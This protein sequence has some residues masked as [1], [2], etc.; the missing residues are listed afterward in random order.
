MM[1]PGAILM[2]DPE[3]MRRR[4][5]DLTKQAEKIR[6]ETAPLRWKRDEALASIA[7]RV[8][9]LETQ[10]KALE[11]PLFDIEQERAIISRALN[12]KTGSVA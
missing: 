4:F 8:T 7:Q 9:A 6:A 10:I 11:A 2:F 12:G 3:T 1:L 5:A